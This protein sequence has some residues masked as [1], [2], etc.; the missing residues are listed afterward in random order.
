MLSRGDLRLNLS[1]RQSGQQQRVRGVRGT[2]F[3]T[4]AIQRMDNVAIVVEDQDAAVGA[5]LL[6]EVAQYETTFRL[7]SLRARQASSSP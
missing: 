3:G 4:M 7:C 6:A 5:E 2:I 1:C